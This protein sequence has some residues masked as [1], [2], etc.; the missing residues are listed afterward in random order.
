MLLEQITLLRREIGM[1]QGNTKKSIQDAVFSEIR[2]AD[3]GDDPLE[4]SRI[5]EESWKYTHGNRESVCKTDTYTYKKCLFFA[6]F[7]L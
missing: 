5:Y 7:Y 6:G 1:E 3:S 4:I 2:Y